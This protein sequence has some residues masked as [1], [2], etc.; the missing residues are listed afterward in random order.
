MTGPSRF[1]VVADD[2]SIRFS[3]K[4]TEVKGRERYRNVAAMPLPPRADND[5]RPGEPGVLIALAKL[6]QRVDETEPYIYPIDRRCR[7]VGR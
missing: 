3:M 1:D 5:D 7:V 2:T 6:T 4:N